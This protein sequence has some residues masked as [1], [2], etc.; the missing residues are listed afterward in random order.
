MGPLVEFIN[1]FPESKKHGWLLAYVGRCGLPLV[2]LVATFYVEWL[3]FGINIVL[4]QVMFI[5]NHCPFVKHLKKD[6]VKLSNFYMKVS[7]YLVCF[8]LF[9]LF[10]IALHHILL[11]T[12]S[13]KR[14]NIF[15]DVYVSGAERACGGCNFFKLCNYSSTGSDDLI[16][17]NL[18]SVEAIEW[19]VQ[20]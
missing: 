15:I 20:H 4:M 1:D 8:L 3:I 14:K 7:Y 10:C 17:S 6:I 12:S 18:S 13:C 2:K 9:L 11:Q 19:F 5:C 16:S